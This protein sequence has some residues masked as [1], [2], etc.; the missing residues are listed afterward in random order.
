ME[1]NRFTDF[2]PEIKR[3][4]WVTVV[5]DTTGEDYFVTLAQTVFTRAILW[6]ARDFRSR[7]L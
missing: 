2:L 4:A 6:A 3:G 5:T 7:V 1:S